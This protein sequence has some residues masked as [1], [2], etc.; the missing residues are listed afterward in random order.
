MIPLE[1]TIEQIANGT[2][3]MLYQSFPI[4]IEQKK[5]GRGFSGVASEEQISGSGHKILISGMDVT[6]F[7]RFNPVVLICHR[8]FAESTLVP[9]AIGT[10]RVRKSG[11]QLLFSNMRFD[12]DPLS[13]LWQSKI[14]CGT[15]R[16]VSVGTQPLEA[17]IKEDVVGRGKNKTTVRYIEVGRSILGELSVCPLGANQG[18]LFDPVPDD[19]SQIQPQID[20]LRAEIE[21][22]KKTLT[23]QHSLDNE[24]NS[25]DTTNEKSEGR[26]GAML[27]EA[28]NCLRKGNNHA[29]N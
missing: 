14:E 17:E 1:Q 6:R 28:A 25:E 27:S 12:A 13:Q 5:S 15:I 20:A 22:M 7:N 19:A 23:P 24:T 11:N 3:G 4:M 2:C 18:A 29:S 8:Q 26:I 16:M 9:G 10:T 21:E